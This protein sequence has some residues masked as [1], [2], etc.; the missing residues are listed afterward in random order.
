M[1]LFYSMLQDTWEEIIILMAALLIMYVCQTSLSGV[2]SRMGFRIAGSHVRGE[3]QYLENQRRY[4]RKPV[5]VEKHCTWCRYSLCRVSCSNQIHTDHDSSEKN[6][7]LEGWTLEYRGYLA[8][9]HYNQARTV[10]ICLDEAP[11]S[12][13]G[14][15]GGYW[16]SS[17]LCSGRG[18][19]IASLPS[20]CEWVGTCVRC[21]YK[22]KKFR[23]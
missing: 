9:Q 6:M 18:M 16:R 19:W 10:F 20:V 3:I 1:L 14:S 21:L 17:A 7:S 4:S 15:F 8:A 13:R 23:F 22:M 11:E 2:T 5:T 12:P